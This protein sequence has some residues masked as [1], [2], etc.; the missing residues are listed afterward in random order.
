MCVCVCVFGWKA[1]TPIISSPYHHHHPFS[2]TD[3]LLEWAAY[4]GQTA[5]ESGN[6]CYIT[7]INKSNTYCDSLKTEYP[8]AAG[9]K[10]YG[11]GPIQVMHCA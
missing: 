4:F 6:F 10:Y 2:P 3:P 5:H 9:Q 7:E 8:C 11:R 1:S